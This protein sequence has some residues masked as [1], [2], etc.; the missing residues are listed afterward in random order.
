MDRALRARVLMAEAASLG[1]TIDDLAVAAATLQLASPPVT[2]ADYVARIAPTFSSA[3]AATYATYWRL[4]VS[5]IGDRRLA[6]VT[7]DDCA[8]VVATAAQRAR[9][10]R[11]GSDGRSSRETCVAA[12][13]ALFGRAQRGGLIARNPAAAIAKPRRRPSRR[14]PLDHAELEE[15]ISAIRTTSRDPD[16]DLLLVRFHLESGARRDGAL[17]LRRRDLD[18]RRATAWLREKFGD[19]REQPL[20]PS[21]IQLLTSHAEHRGGHAPENAVF[22]TRHGEAITRRHYNTLFDRARPCLPWAERTPVSAHVLRYTAINAVGRV[23]GYAV[24]QAFAGHHPPS[25]TGLY[26]RARPSEVAA[27]IATLTGEPHPLTD[28]HDQQSARPELPAPRPAL[29]TC[30]QP[31]IP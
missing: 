12:L 11:A 25:V 18:D 13:R 31:L 6:E 23:A 26:L 19:E 21:L 29:A 20:S 9:D 10:A 24:A 7:V 17:N 4:A 28:D 14:R 22:R 5:L 3:T 2:V 27:A 8:A 30:N 15:L 16:L 1:V